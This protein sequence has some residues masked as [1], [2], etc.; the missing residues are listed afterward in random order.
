MLHIKLISELSLL[1]H[2]D[3]HISFISR[4]VNSFSSFDSVCVCSSTGLFMFCGMTDGAVRIYPLHEKHLSVDNMP[5]YWSLNMHDNNYGQIQGIYPSFDDRF[6]VTCGAD[7]N[8]FTYNILSA[9]EIKKVLRA[10]VPSPRVRKNS[11]DL[12]P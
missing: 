6:L 11:E 10:K 3:F 1:P 4:Y 5:G 7:G 8:I 2:A 12:L 9:E